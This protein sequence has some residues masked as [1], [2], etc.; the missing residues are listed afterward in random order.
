MTEEARMHAHHKRF[1]KLLMLLAAAASFACSAGDA[2]QQADLAAIDPALARVQREVWELWFSG[3]TTRLK[4]ILPADLVTIDNDGSAFS[5]LRDQV[6]ASAGFKDAGGKLIALTFPEMR[7][8]RF[9][10]VVLVYSRYE[11]AYAVGKDTTR[12][13]GRAT[14]V[15]VR[16]AGQWQNPAWHLD[17]GK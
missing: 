9:G 3:D 8:Q 10:D 4:Q 15:F 5:G 17:S 12:Q 16:R 2:A 14:E 13:A 1:G 6:S 7:I 11:L